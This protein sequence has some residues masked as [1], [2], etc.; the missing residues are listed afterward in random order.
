MTTTQ[1][2][3]PDQA[4]RSSAGS[5]PAWAALVAA[6]VGQFLVVLDISVVNVALPGIRSGLDLGATGLQWVVNAYSLTFAGFLL[7]GGR[8]ADLFG[9]KLIFLIGL[10]IF[11]LA[12]LAGGLAPDGGMLIAARAAQGLGAA[13]IAPVTLSMITATFPAG[14]ARTKAI[15]LWTAVG[16]A[17]GATG[18]LVG[19]VLTDYLSWRWVL[20]INVP[21]GA[22]VAVV[23]LL[24]LRNEREAGVRP[25]LDL[26]GAVLVTAGVALLDFGIG[27]TES[28]GWG[29]AQSLL[30]L[31][32][33][34]VALAA[35]VLVESRTAEPLVPLRLFRL[36]SVAVGNL[37]TLVSMMAGFALWY[38]LSLYMQNVLHYSAV[39]TGLSFLPHTAGIII[40]SK[41]A[42][43]LMARIDARILAATGGLMTAAGF[44][45]QSA[46]L[47]ENGT[48]LGSIL[49]PGFVM[50][51]GFGLLMTPLVEASTTGAS[52][53][54]AGA[55]A[56][57]VNTS[58]TIGGAIG[59]T[60]LASAAAR[61]SNLADGYATAFLVAAVITAV[62]TALVALLPR[63][64]RS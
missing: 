21:V 1:E 17:G 22:I 8:A 30:P 4:A 56:G 45:W 32:G 28:H 9:R 10:G 47:N 46:V 38:F 2:R 60:I 12:S 13:I 52:S 61:S 15:A 51:L 11:T 6:S 24:W 39:R 19:G 62:G 36:R 53:S 55:V 50:A 3:G 29:S 20:L 18:G 59:L 54:E 33:G 7:L 40:G 48:F 63:P 58:R 23:A 34:L 57:I 16:T 5:T 37:T 64:Q 35:F 31:V 14:P 42:P 41:L 26:P 44:F 43:G 49:G 27:R 25:R